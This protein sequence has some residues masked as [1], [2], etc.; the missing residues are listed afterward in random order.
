MRRHRHRHLEV[1]EVVAAATAVA[2]EQGLHALDLA[3]VADRLEVAPRSVRAVCPDFADVVAAA[4]RRVVSAELAEMKRV[5]LAHASP[6]AQMRALLDQ[7]T[8]PVFM[9]VD[10]VWVESWS[11]GRRIPQLGVA[12]REEE[13][14]WHVFLSAIIRRGVRSGDFLEV[15]PDDVAAQLLTLIDGVNAYALVG[16]HSDLDRVRLLH[17]S[18]RAHLGPAID[19][20]TTDQAATAV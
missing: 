1:A 9:E 15:D 16:F 12:V 19:A 7:L 8:A 13:G 6:V 14:A 20:L 5:V 4:F 3:V 2:A 10:A 18:A 11:L 17:S